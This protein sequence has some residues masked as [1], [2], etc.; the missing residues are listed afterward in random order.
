MLAL[1]GR[2][3]FRFDSLPGYRAAVAGLLLLSLLLFGGA[4][5]PN[6]F[7][8]VP[9]RLA[10]VL[11]LAAALWP[12]DLSPL[13]VHRPILAFLF[14]CFVLVAAQLIP[15]PSNLWASLPG[16]ALYAEVARATGSQVARPLSLTPDLTINTVGA[17]LP[18]A[19]MLITALYLTTGERKTIAALV[20]VAAVASAVLG[21]A[22]LASSGDALRIYRA[23]SENAPVG[24]FANRNHQALFLA[25]ALPLGAAA[26]VR[27]TQRAPMALVVVLLGACAWL[28]SAAIILTGSRMGL[29]LWSVA[30]VGATGVL[31]VR[32]L[33]RL[34]EKKGLR[35]ASLAAL[36]VLAIAAV[37]FVTQSEAIARLRGADFA[38]DTRTLALPSMIATAR[39]FLPF[40]AGF[41][42]FASVYPAFEPDALLST[43]FLNQAHNEPI[44]LA[45]E[46]G[47]PAILL[48]LIF[49]GWWLRTAFLVL[50]R[51]TGPNQGMAVAAVVVTAMMMV[52]SLV[53]YPLRTPLL[54]SLF[55]F[56]CVEMAIAAKRS[57]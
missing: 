12:L 9:V 48:L 24:I 43:I 4:S 10:A 6:E 55:V 7:A 38:A 27:R 53:D 40:G 57:A 2:R 17:M 3:T 54:G 25:A 5:S 22:Q 34:P 33:L 56:A 26:M 14:A 45:I 49:A 35:N 1:A 37:V 31:Y 29:L 41:G 46:G 20:A 8:Q 15:L 23:T 36:A 16:H 51:R 52:S 13:R 21:L 19:A 32:G 18:P 42:S 44:Q 28:I 50:L 39:T 30:L 47:I 11:C